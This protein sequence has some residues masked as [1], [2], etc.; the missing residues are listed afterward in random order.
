M[1][2]LMFRYLY[3]TAFPTSTLVVRNATGGPLTVQLNGPINKTE[4]LSSTPSSSIQ[5]L[6]HM[7]FHSPLLAICGSGAGKNEI[8]FGPVLMWFL[9]LTASACL[10]VVGQKRTP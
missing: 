7:F 2:K 1:K 10:R 6:E 9:A 3:R 4:T 5:V 8:T